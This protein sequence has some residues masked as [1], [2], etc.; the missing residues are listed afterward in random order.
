MQLRMHHEFSCFPFF[1]FLFC[2]GKYKLTGVRVEQIPISLL[3]FVVESWSVVRLGL[4]LSG[5]ESLVHSEFWTIV[6]GIVFCV[7]V[8]N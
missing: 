5:G 3:T 7:R 2:R 8:T 1:L 6:M 4:C